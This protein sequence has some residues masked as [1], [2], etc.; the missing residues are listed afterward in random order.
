MW[1]IKSLE[2]LYNDFL[3]LQRQI[4]LIG[5]TNWLLFLSTD[6][7]LLCSIIRW[8]CPW[9]YPFLQPKPQSETPAG[10]PRTLSLKQ[11]CP[12]MPS[13]LCWASLDL[14]ALIWEATCNLLWLGDLG[15]FVTQQLL[16]AS[17][18]LLKTGYPCSGGEQRSLWSVLRNNSQFV[19]PI[20]SICL[21]RE[22]KSLYS[23]SRDF[24]LHI[25]GHPIILS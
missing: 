8:P 11:N 21:W 10:H 20:N 15:V 24:M 12:H 14:H 19:L 22:R 23:N 9:Q 13:P 17:S 1:S 7:R 25:R 2:L 3:S 18:H 5:C 4:E 6:H 16:T